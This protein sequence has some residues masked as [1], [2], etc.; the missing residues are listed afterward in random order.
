[1]ILFILICIIQTVS[2][3]ICL[4]NQHV[5]SGAC[6]TC[7]FPQTSPSGLDTNNGDTTCA[8]RTVANLPDC[9]ITLPASGQTSEITLTQDCK[10]DELIF[11]NTNDGTLIINGGGH[12]I[13]ASGTNHRFIRNYDQHSDGTEADEAHIK[14]NNVNIDGFQ[15]GTTDNYGGAFKIRNTWLEAKSCSFTR[16]HAEW[17]GGVVRSEYNTLIY[18]EDCEFVGNRIGSSTSSSAR[19]GLISAAAS[20]ARLIMRSSQIKDT[21]RDSGQDDYIDCKDTEHCVLDEITADVTFAEQNIDLKSDMACPVGVNFDVGSKFSSDV[22]TDYNFC[23]ADETCITVDTFL[24]RCQ[25]Q[26]APSPAMQPSTCDLC[27]G[28][29]NDTECVCNLGTAGPNCEFDVTAVGMQNFF[30]SLKK[31]LPSDA[32]IRNMHKQ[33][34]D[35]IIA[36]KSDI[37]FALELD[38]LQTHQ[39]VIVAKTGKQAELKACEDCIVDINDKVTFVHTDTWTILR[40]TNYVTRQTKISDT[41]YD[42]ECW[43]DGWYNKTRFNTNQREKL[44]ECNG[45]VILVGSQAVV[46]TPQMCSCKAD[47]LTYTCEEDTQAT[48]CYDIDCSDFG[49]HKQVQCTDCTPSECCKFD[50]RKA[51][52]THCESLNAQNFVQEQCCLRDTC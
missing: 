5:S 1:M 45:Y 18:I 8:S 24:I 25:E 9:G 29:C 49:G 36:T 35:Y 12:S 11:H 31:S 13:V 17:R 33:L 32:D 48:S 47:D 44:Y 16:N 38:D 52:N 50:T 41:E 23:K 21:K 7:P 4:R 10:S 14:L 37:H 26:Q 30:T 15:I 51:F 19:G 6:V 2:S 42:M 20:S 27:Q 34:K 40:D 22:G 28:T 43:D 3:E 39:R 46:C